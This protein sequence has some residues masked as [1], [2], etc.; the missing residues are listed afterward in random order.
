MSSRYELVE[1][2]EAH[3]RIADMCR[4]LDVSRS[5]YYEWRTRPESATAQRRRHLT[6]AI[7]EI[8][9]ANHETYGYRRVHAVLARSG[10]TVS[11]ELIRALMRDLGLMPR[12]HTK[13]ALDTRKPAPPPR[14]C[15]STTHET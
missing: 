7:N 14:N 11:P 2:E 4:W 9:T 13:R 3:F 15:R 8:F 5:G 1:A 10:E 6:A 12:A